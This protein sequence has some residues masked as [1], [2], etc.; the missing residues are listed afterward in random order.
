MQPGPILVHVSGV[1]DIMTGEN[2]V[3][4]HSFW[5]TK[6]VEKWGGGELGI[7]TT[8]CVESKASVKVLG[9]LSASIFLSF[10]LYMVWY[11]VLYLYF[12]TYFSFEIFM[13]ATGISC[14]PH[15]SIP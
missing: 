12:I 4:W 13:Y 1:H 6:G 2:K 7:R 11:S 9:A 8:S 15:E 3:I 14:S 5:K 10:S